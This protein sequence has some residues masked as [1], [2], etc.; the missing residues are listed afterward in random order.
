MR[1]WLSDEIV[2]SDSL[3]KLSTRIHISFGVNNNNENKERMKKCS[4]PKVVGELLISYD[5][6][7]PTQ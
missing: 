5:E 3:N 2:F 1:D 7:S 4:F 6:Y